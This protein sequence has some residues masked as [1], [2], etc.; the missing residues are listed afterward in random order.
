MLTEVLTDVHAA[1]LCAINLSHQ[2]WVSTSMQ[3]TRSSLYRGM[4][5]KNISGI[6][7]MKLLVTQE[8]CRRAGEGLPDASSVWPV[9][10]HKG[11]CQQRRDRFV[12]QEVVLQEGA[13]EVKVEWCEGR[14]QEGRM[15]KARDALG[16]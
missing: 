5:K 2:T 8:A 11:T 14:A 7:G 10:G 9:S 15:R 3:M 1:H 16:R 12:K 4:A 6:S 13:V